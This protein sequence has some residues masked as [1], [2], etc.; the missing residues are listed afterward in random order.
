MPRGSA[1]P[2]FAG[3]H[4]PIGADDLPEPRGIRL[5]AAFTQDRD[6][7]VGDALGCEGRDVIHDGRQVDVGR[8]YGYRLV[9]RYTSSAVSGRPRSAVTQM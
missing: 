7:L 4:W 9:T 8:S 3:C 6:A 2:D 5:F 1:G